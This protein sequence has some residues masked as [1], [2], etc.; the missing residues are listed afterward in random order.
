MLSNILED[1]DKKL[2][3]S[4]AAQGYGFEGDSGK[5]IVSAFIYQSKLKC[6]ILHN[7]VWIFFARL[8]QGLEHSADNRRVLSSNLRLRILFCLSIKIIKNT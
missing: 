5:S 7:S 2:T 4:V 3:E 8:A 1:V 6:A